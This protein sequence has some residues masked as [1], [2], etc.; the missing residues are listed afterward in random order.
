MSYSVFRIQGIKT[1]GDLVGI[2][3]HNKDRVSHTNQDIDTSKSKDNIILIECNNY[4]SKFNDIV[5]PMKQ[6]H[7]E[8]MKT[9]RADRIKTFNQHI[10]S[11]KNDVAFEMVFTSDNEFFDGLNRNDIKKWAEKSL[12]FVTK[13][14][15]IERR[16]I[17]HAIVHM[18]EKTP[19]LHVVAVPLV[20]TYN[21]KQNKDVWSISRR[22]YI[23][24]K[25]QLSKAQ[26]IY[27]QRM[28]ESGYKLDRGEK[29]SSKEHTTKAQYIDRLLSENKELKRQ[30]KELRDGV[31][32]DNIKIWD[33]NNKLHNEN[34]SLKI[35]NE[36]MFEY[37]K[38]KGLGEE[39]QIVVNKKIRQKTNNQIKNKRWE[40]EL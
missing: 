26:D 4:N 7:T 12:D 32:K 3:K 40:Q 1:T 15:G 6:E 8:R 16:N 31:P 33:N 24:G 2:S 11:S 39:A 38:E 13:D 37:I 27:N 17:L 34:E 29:G 20:K 28:N 14:L 35:Q 19:H 5:A 30:N 21:K 25:S 23:N 22:Q 9:M 10:N 36:S 18:D